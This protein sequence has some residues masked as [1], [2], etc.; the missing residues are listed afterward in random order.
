MLSYAELHC[1]I[2]AQQ[3]IAS[4]QTATLKQAISQYALM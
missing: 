3:K 2:H 4:P 1:F